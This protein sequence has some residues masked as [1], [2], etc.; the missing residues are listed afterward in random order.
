M[1]TRATGVRR[2]VREPLLHFLLIGAAIFIGYTSIEGEAGAAQS[3]DEIRLT[4]DD[5]LQL[6]TVFVA[7][8]NREPTAAEFQALLENRI[9]EE[10]LY[11]EAL[12]L[13][14]DE[15]DTIVR[16]RM[17]QKMQFLAEDMATAREPATEELRAWYQD[18]GELFAL[19]PR[20]SFRHLYFAA[21][22]RRERAK[23]DAEVA[24]ARLVGEA[25]DSPSVAPLADTFMFQDYYGDRTPRELAREFGPDFARAVLQLTPGSWQGPIESGYGWHLVFIDSLVSGRIPAFAEVE[26]D[27]KTAWLAEQKA[28]AREKA[29]REIRAKY[30]LVVPG[31]PEGEQ[32]FGGESAPSDSAALALEAQ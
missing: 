15:N 28:L 7:K 4:M 19:P 12:S 26:P 14:L 32:D 17:A 5:L 20:V 25:Q 11:R 10:V 31:P 16:R 8:W 18:H 1:A 24:L 22:L 13:G 30:I 29:Y 27:V 21:D 23:S 9:R 6:E 3:P 2:L